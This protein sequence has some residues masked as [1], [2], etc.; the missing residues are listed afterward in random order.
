MAIAPANRLRQ[1]AAAGCVIAVLGFAAIPFAIAS[2]TTDP[3]APTAFEP[4]VR[5]A[6]W[7]SW[8]GGGRPLFNRG[9]APTNFAPAVPDTPHPAVARIIV[10]EDGATAYGSGTLIDV[11]DEYGLVITNWH[12]V[13]DSQGTVEVVFPGGFRS[14]ARP[15]KVDSDWDLGGARDLAAAD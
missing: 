10:P 12:V 13:R 6:A 2:P 8:L 4:V 5:T 9:S 14:H 3:L 15:L 1:L 11:R 7:P